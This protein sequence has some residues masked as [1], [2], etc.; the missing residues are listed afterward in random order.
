MPHNYIYFTSEYPYFIV[1]RLIQS[2]FRFTEWHNASAL[3]SFYPHNM[4][5]FSNRYKFVESTVVFM[6]FADE[7]AFSSSL[8]LSLS[9]R[10]PFVCDCVNYARNVF[11]AYLTRF[12]CDAM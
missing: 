10:S 9:Y 11:I 12:H 1:V 8:R 5:V 2:L 3:P 4:Y 7:V 6:M